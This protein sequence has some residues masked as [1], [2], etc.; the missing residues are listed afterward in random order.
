MNLMMHIDDDHW[1]SMIPASSWGSLE[2][3]PSSAWRSCQTC[4]SQ[5]IFKFSYCPGREAWFSWCEYWILNL[6]LCN[7]ALGQAMATAT[8]A[9]HSTHS[10][11]D[12]L[13]SNSASQQ[14][15]LWLRL[16]IN[17]L[18]TDYMIPYDAVSVWV[19][20]KMTW[21]HEVEIYPVIL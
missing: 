20:V 8:I 6:N 1:S 19:S 12:L 7:P 21:K 15:Y 5:T 11:S 2:S 10:L 16:V 17:W 14:F 9:V 3:E 13:I 4:F 18:I